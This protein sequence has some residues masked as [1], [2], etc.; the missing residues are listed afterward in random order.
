MSDLNLSQLVQQYH[1]ST[2][3]ML[4]QKQI[5]SMSEAILI[6]AVRGTFDNFPVE[7]RPLLDAFTQDYSSTKWFNPS[8]VTA[9]LGDVFNQT[10]ADIRTMSADNGLALDD[11]RV[12]DIFNIMVMKLSHF[13]YSRP[14]VRKLLGIKKG[15]FS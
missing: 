1:G 13:A 9:D 4:V 3:P 7:H 14:D 10:I 6:Q 5:R 15:W 8:I 2:L 12:F 11:D